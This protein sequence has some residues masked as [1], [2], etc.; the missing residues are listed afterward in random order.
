MTV[1]KTTISKNKPPEIVYTNYKYFTSQN[2]NDKLKFFFSKENIDCC[3][4]SNQ[5]FLNGL[6]MF[7][8]CLRLCEKPYLEDPNLKILIS[9]KE[10][11]SH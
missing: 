10:R 5:T 11:T 1:L 6:I 3:R 9:K 4:K 7:H 8:M 2:C